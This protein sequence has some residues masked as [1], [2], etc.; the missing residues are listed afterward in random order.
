[1]EGMKRVRGVVCRKLERE[2]AEGQS[3]KVNMVCRETEREN[4]EGQSEKVNM[5]WEMWLIFYVL[6]VVHLE[7]HDDVP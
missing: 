5:E 2:N 6:R 3:E 7:S 4:A 1:V